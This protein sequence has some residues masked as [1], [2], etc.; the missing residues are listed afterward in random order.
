MQFSWKVSKHSFKVYK[1]KY[2][3]IFE[4]ERNENDKVNYNWIR[5]KHETVTP[6]LTGW[7]NKESISA[8][9]QF[10]RLPLFLTSSSLPHC[11]HIMS[12]L[13]AEI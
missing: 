10:L 11:L 8:V 6:A 1:I 5:D 9:G 3:R 12:L 2:N 13:F 7:M 4:F